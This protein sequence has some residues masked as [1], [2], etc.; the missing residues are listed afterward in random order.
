M[1]GNDVECPI[2]GQMVDDAKFDYSASSH[3]S[4]HMFKHLEPWRKR[5]QCNNICPCGYLIRNSIRMHMH[6]QGGWQKHWD[7]A[8]R[9]EWLDFLMGVKYE[10]KQSS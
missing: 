10:Q 7:E 9:T 5:Y 8:C 1:A 6:E 2:C 3:M 4:Q